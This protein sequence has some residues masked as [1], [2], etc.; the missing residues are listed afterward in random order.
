MSGGLGFV[1]ASVGSQLVLAGVPSGA[2]F[3][4]T[5]ACR[6][7]CYWLP[8]LA[9][10][11]AY[12]IFRHRYL[13]AWRRSSGTSKRHVATSRM[14]TRVGRRGA[15]RKGAGLWNRSASIEPDGDGFP[16]LTGMADWERSGRPDSCRR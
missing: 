2:A 6:L 5:L 14:P 15:A 16:S 10:G 7:L 4:A 13:A 8:V 11:V 1:E 3:V 9:G 12:L